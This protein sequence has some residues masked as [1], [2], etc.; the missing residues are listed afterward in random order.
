MENETYLGGPWQ[1]RGG[2]SGWIQAAKSG[3]RLGGLSDR[4]GMENETDL[5]G[6]WQP[7]GGLSDRSDIERV[8]LGGVPCCGVHEEGY[9]TV[10][11]WRM[12]PAVDLGSL[13]RL[14]D[15]ILACGNEAWRLRPRKK[16]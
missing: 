1:P 10:L 4:S 11:A 6:P 9:L 13:G 5:G 7:K 16:D 15:W 8:R 14:S 3:G 12:R 2:L